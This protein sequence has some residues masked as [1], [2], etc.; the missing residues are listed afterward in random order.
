MRKVRGKNSALG[1]ASLSERNAGLG[2]RKMMESLV[3]NHVDYK[4]IENK[5]QSD[6]KGEQVDVISKSN[7]HSTPSNEIE[8][9][10]VSNSSESI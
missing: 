3:N 4:K 6:D 9:D 2:K 1:K 8:I 5:F 7:T 10:K